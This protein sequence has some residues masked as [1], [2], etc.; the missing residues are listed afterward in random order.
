MPNF[1]LV[2]QAS[3]DKILKAEVFHTN[4]QL[5]AAYLILDYVP[6]SKCFLV[7][8]CVIKARDPR[9]QRISVAAS[10]FR[11]SNLVLEGTLTTEPIPEG[12]PKVVLPPSQTT[13]VATS[14]HLASIEEE[15]AV[16]VPDSE[17]EFEVFNR[18][19]SPKTST[20]DLS[21]PFNPI[22]DEMGI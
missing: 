7:P 4:G 9:L 14:S 2:N 11:L 8:K 18:A 19:W 3:L 16:E 10:G 13:G 20:F 5:R 17:D 22:I 21:P 1:N 12:I 6:I 15:E